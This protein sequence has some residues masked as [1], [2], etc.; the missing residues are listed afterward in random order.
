VPK[1]EDHCKES[2]ELFGDTYEALHKWLDEFCGSKHY[3]MRH[4]RVRHHEA[5]I[6]EAIALFGEKA[7]DVARQHIISDLKE[8]GWTELDPFPRDEDH[9]VRMGLF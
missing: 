5:G 4:R 7:G 9:Y 2:L 3:G 1:L 8:E 6:R